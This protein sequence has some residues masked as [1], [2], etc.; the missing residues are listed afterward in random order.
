MR[1]VPFT[2]LLPLSLASLPEASTQRGTLT[3]RA[4]GE[5]G[6]EH[7]RRHSPPPLIPA[8][9]AEAELYPTTRG[10]YRYEPDEP[11]RD[12]SSAIPAISVRPTSS[13][14]I[15]AGAWAWQSQLES[16]Y[17]LRDATVHQATWYV[18]TAGRSRLSFSL[19]ARRRT[20]RRGDR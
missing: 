12:A 6:I 19:P 2:G 8:E 14:A 1:S 17:A 10:A 18:Q 11:I 9:L 4:L 7:R 5:T 20:A 13:P 15:E 3:I 16:R